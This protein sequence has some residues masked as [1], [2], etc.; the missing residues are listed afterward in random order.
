[1]RKSFQEKISKYNLI[2]KKSFFSFFSLLLFPPFR[3]VLDSSLFFPP[4]LLLPL[5]LPLTIAIVH[6]CLL[7]SSNSLP[8]SFFSDL[9]KYYNAFLVPPPSLIH[10]NPVADK[11]HIFF[12][13]LVNSKILTHAT[14]NPR[15]H[16]LLKMITK[17][18]NEEQ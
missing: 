14:L 13:S 15:M 4:V 11:K 3:P 10:E 9:C 1:M 18:K 17:F 6:P 12:I 2:A 8:F 7:F 5:Y 16:V